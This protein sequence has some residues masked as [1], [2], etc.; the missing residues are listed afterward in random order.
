MYRV[1]QKIQMEL[2]LLCVWGERAILYNAETALR[3]KHEI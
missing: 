2:I 3:L 1:L